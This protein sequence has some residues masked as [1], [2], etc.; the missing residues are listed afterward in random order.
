MVHAKT[1]CNVNGSINIK[2]RN[3]Y[4]AGRIYHLAKVKVKNYQF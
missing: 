1:D 4:L 3:C 2:T